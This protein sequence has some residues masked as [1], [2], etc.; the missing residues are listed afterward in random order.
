MG[1]CLSGKAQDAAFAEA[2]EFCMHDEICRRVI[3]RAGIAT[4]NVC[5]ALCRE[6]L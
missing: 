3:F 1:L 5:D 2:G 4:W 6:L